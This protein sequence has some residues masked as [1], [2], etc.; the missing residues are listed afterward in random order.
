MVFGLCAAHKDKEPLKL[1]HHA[2][3]EDISALSTSSDA[4]VSMRKQKWSIK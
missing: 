2:T 3:Y 4:H 1:P